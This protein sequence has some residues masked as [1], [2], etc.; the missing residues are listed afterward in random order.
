MYYCY[1][2]K[3]IGSYYYVGRTRN[4]N[5][6]IT[7]HIE[8][9]GSIWTTLHPPKKIKQIIPN[10]DQFDEDKYTKQMMAKYGIDKVRGGSYCKVTLDQHTIQYLQ[11]ELDGATDKCYRCGREGH[12]ASNCYAQTTIDSSYDLN[13]SK[14]YQQQVPKQPQYTVKC[15]RCGRKGHYSSNCYARTT[16]DGYTLDESDEFSSYYFLTSESY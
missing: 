14:N 1:I 7:D 11:H 12:Y 8:G 15:Y 3:L 4:P 2:L 5:M 10:C 16:I 6:R 13:E 9:S